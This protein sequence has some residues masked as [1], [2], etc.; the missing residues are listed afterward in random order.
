[1]TIAIAIA[2]AD[3]IVLA[4]DSATLSTDGRGT[5]QIFHQKQKLFQLHDK[6][7]IGL[8]TFGLNRIG[9]E[10]VATLCRELRLMFSGKMKNGNDDWSLGDKWKI[11]EIVDRVK[12]YIF[13]KYYL[14]HF[15][16]LP[17]DKRMGFYIAG[18]SSG[19]RSPE[20]AEMSFDGEHVIGPVFTTAKNTIS[21]KFGGT[22]EATHRLML[23]Y[24]PGL[25]KVM[26][27]AGVEKDMIKKVIELA[28]RKLFPPILHPHMPLLEIADVARFLVRNE[29]KFQ[30]Y[31]PEPDTVGG[32]I[33]LA[34]IGRIDGF[35][36]LQRVGSKSTKKKRK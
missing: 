28:K 2:S 12:E 21:I 34:T 5:K 35:R 1:M 22:H 26:E 30:H 13:D 27:E 15:P 9:T 31:S 29:K 33:Q 3:G 25:A 23:G 18:F 20:L 4:T 32:E 36:W 19:Q 6:H 14:P 8:I 11:T 10:S 7:P 16:K 24:S 17:K